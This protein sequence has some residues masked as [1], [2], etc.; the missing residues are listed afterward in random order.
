MTA[1]LP[2]SAGGEPHEADPAAILD[3][4]EELAYA[5]EI[6]PDG[7]YIDHESWP[8]FVRVLGGPIP[9][10]TPPGVFWESRVHPEDLGDWQRFNQQLLDGEDAE[11]KYRLV[12]LDGV[13]RMLWD[14][15]RPRVQPGGRTLVQGIISD[16]TVRGGRRGEA[17][18]A[19]CST[20]SASTSTSRSRTP[21]AGSR[22]CSRARAPTA[23][24][25][26]RSPMRR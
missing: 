13:T 5:G 15:A 2:P 16:V 20:S 14:R 12:G 10:G 24:W 25:A 3:L 1:P 22:S 6:T 19:G 8:T 23:C 18:S 7:Q 26:A 9:E 21:T 11:V 17:G 4:L